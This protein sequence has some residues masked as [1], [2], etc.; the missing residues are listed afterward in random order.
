MM[1]LSGANPL[2]VILG[3]AGSL[4]AAEMVT[5]RPAAPRVSPPLPT[6][7]PP[8]LNRI[9]P[10]V[11]V[12]PGAGTIS[13]AETIHAASANPIVNHFHIRLFS[14]AIMPYNP[15]IVYRKNQVLSTK[16]P[17][18]SRKNLIY[19]HIFLLKNNAYQLKKLYYC[20]IFYRVSKKDPRVGNAQ[21]TGVNF[22]I[23]QTRWITPA[24]NHQLSWER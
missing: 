23:R 4:T 13:P 2:P 6:A 5:P 11:S 3:A 16:R 8:D 22:M 7:G 24:G 17:Q 20:I 18:K 12:A 21:N 9:T 15:L 14:P 19:S 10:S 1:D